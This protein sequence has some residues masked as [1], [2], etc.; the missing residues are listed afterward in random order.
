VA[1][2]AATFGRGAMTNGWTDVANADVVLIMGGNPAENHP[3][4][5]R[6]AME[7]RRNRKAKLVV[8]DPRFNRS[9]AVADLY[10]PLRAGTDIAFLGGLIH[11]ALTRGLY[12][13]DYVKEHTNASFLVDESFSF[14]DGYFSG[15]NGEDRRYDKSTWRYQLDEKGFA[16][17]DP[18]LEN[19]RSV[20]Q[21][22]REHYSRYTAERVA[23]ICG[24]TAAEFE[25]AAE[26][27]CST[28][29]AGRSGTILYALGWTQHSHSVQLIHAAAMLQLLLGNIGIPGGGVNAQRG[30]SNIQG[31]TDM[32]AWNML[33]GYLR[34][35]IAPW[36][37]LAEYVAASSPKPLRPD[38]LNYWSN[39]SK[40]MVS[41]LKS[42]YGA[43]ASASN[44]FGYQWLPKLPEGEN[45]GWGFLFDRMA[46]GEM[47]GMISFGMNPVAN[48]PNSAKMLQGLAKL[49]WLAVVENFETETAAFWK[50]GALAAE[51][52]PEAPAAA[53]VATEV[54]LLPA[55]CFAEKD[56]TF[57]NS[58]RWLQWK[59]AALEPPG[60]AKPD[61]EILGLLFLELSRL[62]QEEGGKG[63]DSFLAMDWGYGNPRSPDLEE[64]AKELN[65]QVI[66]TGRQ[67]SGF[68][69]LEDDGS[70]RCGNWLYSGSYTEA[71][72]MMARRGQDD[73]TG[74]GLYPE[75][76]WSWPSNRRIMYNRASA[77]AQGK[78]WDPTRAPLRFE[79][80]RYLGDIPDFKADASPE[81]LGAFIMLP[82]GVAKLFTPDFAEGPFPEHYE[83]VES[84]VANALHPEVGSNPVATVFRGE[85]DP[86]GTP[87]QYPYVALTYRL[88]EHFH[89]WTKHVETNSLLQSSF[90]VEVP[91][92]LAR[93]KG[94]QSGDRVRVTSA[95][96]AVEGAAMVT[97]RVRP[98]DVGGK[99]IYQVGLPIHWGFL[100]RVKG[101]LINNLTPSVLDPN[102]GT[103]EY[104]GFLVNLEKA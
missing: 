67:V 22:L 65:G 47:E 54:F 52:Y 59:R 57:V 36:R 85:L 55:A 49:K 21:L 14:E 15:W 97:K 82:E 60:E 34:V 27:V 77:D 93:E 104:K 75:Y 38:S 83:P 90:F 68:A 69:E 43:K 64:V 26:I 8:V 61:Q 10:V 33:P 96:G 87:E 56:G 71:G 103:P 31:A 9:A 44:D 66:A 41:L 39:T 4:G 18:T 99:T 80:G 28:G 53:D 7:A 92:E 86:L 5:F 101:P 32:G 50:A 94:I 62:Y 30:H 81:D 63:K 84:P 37:T 78:P 19:P 25:R 72:N 17:I 89:Y 40:F 91:E 58:S 88:T 35:P 13:A 11:Y 76:S 48:G 73:P 100:G 74:L 46:L 95:R 2:L 20:F 42:Y 70:T 102:A 23:A 12:H 51:Y 1:S 3:V 24:C 29:R 79:N 6:F 16:R 98:L 45:H